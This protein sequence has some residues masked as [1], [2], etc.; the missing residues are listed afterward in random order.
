[1][2]RPIRVDSSEFRDEVRGGG[3]WLSKCVGRKSTLK[4]TYKIDNCAF[5]KTTFSIVCNYFLNAAYIKSD[6]PIKSF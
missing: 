5:L 3:H 1:M 6:F 2:P 4:I